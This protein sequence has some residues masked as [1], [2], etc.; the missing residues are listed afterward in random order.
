MRKH[1]KLGCDAL[2]GRI[3]ARDNFKAGFT[4]WG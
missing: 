1:W 3:L 4:A 2:A